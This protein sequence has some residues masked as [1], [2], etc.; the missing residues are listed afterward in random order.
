MHCF[1][2]SHFLNNL[3]RKGVD[4]TLLD[5]FDGILTFSLML[6]VVGAVHTLTALAELT[7]RKTLTVPVAYTAHKPT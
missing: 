7:G 2:L 5:T 4:A 1:I 6:A 3:W